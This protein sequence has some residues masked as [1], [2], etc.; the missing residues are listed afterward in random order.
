MRNTTHNNGAIIIGGDF[1]GLGIAHNLSPLGIPVTIIDPNFCIGKFSRFV[2]R[3]YKCPSLTNIEAFTAF[4]EQLAIEENLNNWVVYPT[5][6]EA[7]YILSKHKDHLSQYYLIPTPKWEITKYAYDK[8]LTY[9][10][11]EKL[12]LPIYS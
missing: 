8:K 2:Q 3:Y 6:D 7:V 4:L 10:L 9:Q 1:Q 12:N 5:S 11:A